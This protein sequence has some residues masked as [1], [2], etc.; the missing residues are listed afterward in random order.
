MPDEPINPAY[1]I[2]PPRNLPGKKKKPQ[3]PEESEHKDNP[4][5]QPPNDQP[6]GI[7]DT[8]V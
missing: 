6:K 3:P 1:P 5:D 7:I 2:S 4:P 8:Y